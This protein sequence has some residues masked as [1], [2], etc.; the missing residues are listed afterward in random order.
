MAQ[1]VGKVT[2][3]QGEIYFQGGVFGRRP[4]LFVM[5]ALWA[6]GFKSG[7]KRDSVEGLIKE[8]FMTKILTIALLCA[9]MAVLA[10]CE[11]VKGVGK[12]IQN[13]SEA[14]QRKL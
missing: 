6:V 12:D 5:V 8:F 4:S 14:V 11:T 3:Y 2:A 13:S 7:A 10:A 9:T 1:L